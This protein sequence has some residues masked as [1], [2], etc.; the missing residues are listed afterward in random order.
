MQD[1][2]NFD[3]NSVGLKSN[4]IFGLPFTEEQAQLVLLPVPW[5]VTVSYRVGTAQGPDHIFEAAMQVDLFDPDVKDGWK[6]GFYM[7]PVDKN[8]RKKSDYLRQCAEL[9]LSHMVE[10]GDVADN[11]QLSHK[12]TEINNNGEILRDWVYEMTSNLLKRGKKVGLIGGDHSTPLGFI[13]ALGDVHSD[14]GIL[15]IDAHA[16]LRIAYE[17]FTYSHASIMYNTLKEVPQVKKLVQVGI[18]DYC[19]EELEMIEQSNGR[20]RTFFDKDI[21]EQ[22]YEGATWKQICTQIIDSL[23]QK[24]YISFDIDGLD[25]KLCPNTGTPVPGGFETEQIFYL[26]KMLHQ[27]GKEII[28]FDLNEVSNGFTHGDGIDAI[29]GARVLFKL[30]N[31]MVG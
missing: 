19:N 11:E 12:L 30:C 14:F 18:R 29:V 26:F 31:Y 28:G 23:P 21:K 16:D 17:G 7:M 9:I 15:Q 24:V 1:L 20:I 5:E 6:K 22:Q 25:P 27:S 2:T 13:K 10:G 8:I 4:N 3:P